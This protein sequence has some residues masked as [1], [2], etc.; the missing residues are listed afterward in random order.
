VFVWCL[1]LVT[2]HPEARIGGISGDFFVHYRL[3][4]LS[5]LTYTIL[6]YIIILSSYCFYY[7]KNYVRDVCDL[8]TREFI[9][10]A[11]FQACWKA[12]GLTD[13]DLIVLENTLLNNPH[14]GDVIQ[15]TNGTRKMRVRIGKQGK[16]GG[17]R[18]VYLDVFEKKRIYFLF[19]YPKNVQ[20]NLTPAQEK[21]LRELAN[22][23]KKE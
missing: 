5:L 21:I 4:A 2:V 18:A 22:A 3:A 16:S 12:M 6:S 20:E 1:L 17:G 23:I 19:A 8:L 7:V 13:N 15:G 14:A 9:Y 10:T 11:P